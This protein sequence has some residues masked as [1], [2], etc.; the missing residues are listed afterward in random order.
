MYT[1]RT[2]RNLSVSLLFSATTDIVSDCKCVLVRSPKDHLS[3]MCLYSTF[4][5][6]VGLLAFTAYNNNNNNNIALQTYRSK[7]VGILIPTTTLS[8]WQNIQCLLFYDS[9]EYGPGDHIKC[10]FNI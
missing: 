5:N 10:S 6:E 3:V 2:N 1:N 7:K 8:L 9:T 4:H